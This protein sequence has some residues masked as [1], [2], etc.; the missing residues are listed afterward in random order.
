MASLSADQL[1][2][3]AQQLHDVAVAIGQ[4]RLD[5]IHDGAQLDDPCIVQLLG[6]QFSLLNTSSSFALQAA[7]IE[8]ADADKAADVIKSA[9]DDANV[10]IKN[11]AKIN[12]VVTVASAVIVLAAAVMTGNMGSIFS[13]VDGVKNAIGGEPAVSAV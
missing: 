6:L 1:T 12:K 2:S 4:F 9:T 11:A 3:I 13:A 8:L 10:A 5:Q 7:T